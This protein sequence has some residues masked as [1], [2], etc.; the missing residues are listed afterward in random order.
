MSFPYFCFMKLCLG[1]WGIFCG[2]GLGFVS[3]EMGKNLKLAQL[4]TLSHWSERAPS[5][6]AA[7]LSLVFLGT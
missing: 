1:L 6:S 2:L 4:I 5:R 3:N 7:S